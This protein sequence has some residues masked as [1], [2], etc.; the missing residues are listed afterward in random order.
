VLPATTSQ[1][2]ASKLLAQTDAATLNAAEEGRWRQPCASPALV[3]P[4]PSRVPRL[5]FLGLL[6][7]LAPGGRG[8]PSL[9]VLLLFLALL[10]VRAAV[11]V[12]RG[13]P[14]LL[15]LRLCGGLT[16]V[17]VVV[18]MAAAVAAALCRGALLGGGRG[19]RGGLVGGPAAALGVGRVGAVSGE[20]DAGEDAG[21]RLRRR[22]GC[23]GG[24]G[25]V[26]RR[27]RRGRW[28]LDVVVAV[29][30]GALLA[31]AGG[32]TRLPVGA[33]RRRRATLRSVRLGPRSLENKTK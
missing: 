32:A 26:P 21:L 18:A 5:L 13:G 3:V 28:E 20:A 30:G 16:V 4:G 10:F 29:G 17:L 24:L 31:G 33:G 6:L 7:A 15:L 12:A 9:E 1:L 19:V 2:Q 11:V 27:R 25:L 22:R 23:R 14:T 8:R